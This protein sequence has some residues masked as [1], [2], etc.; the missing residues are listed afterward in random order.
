MPEN[1]I[2]IL[3]NETC[4]LLMATINLLDQLQ[5]NDKYVQVNYNF[6]IGLK[7]YFIKPPF[8]PTHALLNLLN[9]NKENL[10]E[11]IST[12]TNEI[13]ELDLKP[14][15]LLEKS[16]INHSIELLVFSITTLVFFISE[17][18]TRSDLL[19]LI[20]SNCDKKNKRELIHFKKIA[21]HILDDS[22]EVMLDINTRTPFN[23]R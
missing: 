15:T 18:E 23:E 20:E 5:S 9:R 3:G 17:I 22:K 2:A 6:F 16:D 21:N 8:N 1:S 19:S 12:S 13:L 10:E 11:I 14:S 7:P 4:R